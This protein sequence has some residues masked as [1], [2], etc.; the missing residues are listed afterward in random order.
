MHFISFS[1]I[2]LPHGFDLYRVRY[3][4]VYCVVLTSL[5]QSDDDILNQLSGNTH[6]LSCATGV[7]NLITEIGESLKY[8]VVI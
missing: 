3:F 6:V 4:L 8:V 1:T 5:L 2:G 7:M